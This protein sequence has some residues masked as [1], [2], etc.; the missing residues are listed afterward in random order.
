MEM[1]RNQSLLFRSNFRIDAVNVY[2][3]EHGTSAQKEK[4]KKV[5][6]LTLLCMFPLRLR[7]FPFDFNFQPNSDIRRQ[8][9]KQFY[10]F[11]VQSYVT[12]ARGNDKRTL[13]HCL[14]ARKV[15]S[16]WKVCV[17]CDCS[18]S[19]HTYILRLLDTLDYGTVNH[20]HWSNRSIVTIAPTTPNKK[21]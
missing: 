21:K 18:Q 11:M 20:K 12:I 15:C 10:Y 13:S 3:W 4:K 19:V 14:I 7:T 1:H 17:P 2:T 5:N 6:S 8:H 9:E 16:I